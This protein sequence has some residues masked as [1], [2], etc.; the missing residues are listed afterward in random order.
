MPAAAQYYLTCT[1]CSELATENNKTLFGETDDC[2][3]A[4][5]V[6]LGWW[7]NAIDSF[8]SEQYTVDYCPKCVKQGK[9]LLS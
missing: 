7:S 1:G 2:V 4:E 9:H 8:I 6:D 3:R 5:A